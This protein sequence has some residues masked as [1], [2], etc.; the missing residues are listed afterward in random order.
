MP[1][2]SELTNFRRGVAPLSL[3][4]LLSRG[5]MY[6]YQLV[7]EMARQSGGTLA[8]QEGSLYPGL[9]RLQEAGYIS[10][11]RVKVGKRMTRVYYHIEPS[12]EAFLKALAEE[13]TA[14]TDGVFRILRGD[15]DEHA[16]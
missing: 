1:N 12:G 9:Y 2:K 5:D 7:Q 4:A 8:M 14:V 3:L 13:Y 11:Y 16:E 6:G 15:A 10:D